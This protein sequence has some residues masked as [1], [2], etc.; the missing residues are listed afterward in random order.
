[1]GRSWHRRYDR[2]VET[3]G[4]IKRGEPFFVLVQECFGGEKGHP[5]R[6]YVSSSAACW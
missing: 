6:F 1:M 4:R 5:Q 2:G 3:D